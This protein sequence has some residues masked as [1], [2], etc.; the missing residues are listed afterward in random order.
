VKE[1][2][3]YDHVIPLLSELH[4]LPIE[5]RIRYKIAVLTFKAGSKSKLSYLANLVSTRIPA[6]E[7]RSNSRRP[8][9]ATCYKCQNCFL[10]PS[11]STRCSSS[12]PST[13]RNTAL[14]LKTFKSRLQFFYTISHYAVDRVTNPHLQFD[15][16][17]DDK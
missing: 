13:V 3:K 16:T 1:R 17:D 12:L 4:W 14:S 15:V 11:F 6:S 7:L 9:L 5:A 10:K 8:N 2:S